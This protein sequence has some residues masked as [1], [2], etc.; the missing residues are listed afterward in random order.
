LLVGRCGF[1]SDIEEKVI[2]ITELSR[3]AL[4][5][6]LTLSCENVCDENVQPGFTPGHF[7]GDVVAF[8]N[9]RRLQNQV[10]PAV[11]RRR[12]QWFPK[13]NSLSGSTVLHDL[14]VACTEIL[15][16]GSSKINPDKKLLNES[17]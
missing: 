8:S 12:S 13:N 7:K 9:H 15:C 5:G 14:Y 16:F 2:K 1:F 4:L 6:E 10:L 17:P 11:R 3:L